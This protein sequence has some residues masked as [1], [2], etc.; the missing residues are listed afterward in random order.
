MASNSTH[1]VTSGSSFLILLGRVCFAAIFIFAGSRHFM[2]QTIAYAA[3]QGVPM[4][5]ILVP[6][7]GALAVLGGLSVLLGYRAK[8]GAWLIVLFLIGV[9]PKMHAFWTVTDPMRYQMQLAHFMK[10]VSMLGAALWVTQW[11]SGPMSLDGRS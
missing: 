8:I 7:S 5:S 1:G 11:G 2:S 10:N 4:A 6:F 3:S 9:T